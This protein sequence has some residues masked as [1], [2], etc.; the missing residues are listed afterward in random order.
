ML[1]LTDRNTQSTPIP[2][3]TCPL[4]ISTQDNQCLSPDEGDR[5][6]KLYDLRYNCS[7]FGPDCPCKRDKAKK[8]AEKYY[9][10]AKMM[11]YQPHKYVNG[12]HKVMMTGKYHKNSVQTGF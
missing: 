3:D 8:Q 9:D 7:E 12:T 10:N 4:D 1:F 6:K 2:D 5:L 11:E